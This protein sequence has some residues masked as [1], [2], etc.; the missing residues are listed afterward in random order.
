MTPEQ[1]ADALISEHIGW[2]RSNEKEWR[3]VVD[4]IRAAEVDALERAAQ[5]AEGHASCDIRGAMT[6]A[7]N[8]ASQHIA[9]RIRSL[10]GT[11]GTPSTS[12]TL[13]DEITELLRA[14]FVVE[15][16][17]GEEADCWSCRAVRSLRAIGRW[18]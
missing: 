11:P 1:R 13:A 8:H 2:L 7:E 6:L 18:P 10:K 16:C 3:V 15:G 5:V 4:A 9:R 17:D 12:E 14:G